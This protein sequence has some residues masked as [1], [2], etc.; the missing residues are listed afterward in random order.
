MLGLLEQMKLA[1]SKCPFFSDLRCILVYGHVQK[2][3]HFGEA[4][5][6]CL[7]SFLFSMYHFIPSYT[8]VL[9]DY[10]LKISSKSH[11]RFQSYELL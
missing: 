7:I 11:K 1:I 6:E 4:N 10:L 9:T 8:Y 5:I 3:G 2:M